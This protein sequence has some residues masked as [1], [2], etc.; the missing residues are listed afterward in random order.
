MAISKNIARTVRRSTRRTVR[1]GSRRI[2]KA[3]G[4]SGGLLTA[5]IATG[6]FGALAEIFKNKE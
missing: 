6:A 4:L 2:L 3:T 5:A 1:K